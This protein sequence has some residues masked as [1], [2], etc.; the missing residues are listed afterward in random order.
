[1]SEHKTRRIILIAALGTIGFIFVAG[2]TFGVLV[3]LNPRTHQMN[4]TAPI[5]SDAATAAKTYLAHG[6]YSKAR[7]SF[8]TALTKAEA[9]GDYTRVQY[10]KQQID[11][12]DSTLHSDSPRATSDPDVTQYAHPAAPPRQPKP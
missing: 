3:L 7:A 11:F 12:I 6:E 9:S 2:A 1:M 8:Q 5:S 4:K 10:Y